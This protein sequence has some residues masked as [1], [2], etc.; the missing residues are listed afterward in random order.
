MIGAFNIVGAVLENDLHM[1]RFLWPHEIIWKN[2]VVQQRANRYFSKGS[3]HHDHNDINNDIN[4]DSN[5]DINN[6][7]FDTKPSTSVHELPEFMQE[8][9]VDW[10][11]RYGI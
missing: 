10:L 3:N 1:F 7:T 11:L 4:N 6:D 8:L 5:H 2:E 9:S